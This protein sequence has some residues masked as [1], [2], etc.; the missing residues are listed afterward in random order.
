MR[1]KDLKRKVA[2]LYVSRLPIDDE[3]IVAAGVKSVND[4]RTAARAQARPKAAARKRVWAACAIAAL[5]LAIAPIAI[6]GANGLFGN[7][8]A[9]ATPSADDWRQSNSIAETARLTDATL[10]YLD[11]VRVMTERV[12]REDGYALRETTKI[13]PSG[14]MRQA[15]LTVAVGYAPEKWDEYREM[16]IVA[17][18]NGIDVRGR[19]SEGLLTL[20]FAD[21]PKENE[22]LICVS[23]AELVDAPNVLDLLKIVD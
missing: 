20:Y 21:L 3:R 1:K 7:A 16:P 13:A 14:T 12:D 17:H 19:A 8:K 15:R 5:L 11:G 18:F 6:L 9:D 10:Y 2:E 22:Y 4:A 23:G